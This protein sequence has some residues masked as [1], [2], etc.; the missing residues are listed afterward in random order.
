MIDRHQSDSIY[1]DEYFYSTDPPLNPIARGKPTPQAIDPREKT[2]TAREV[3]PDTSRRGR[4]PTRAAAARPYTSRQGRRPSRDADACAACC[5]AARGA[6]RRCT[7]SASESEGILGEAKAKAKAEAA[8]GL[9]SG[10]RRAGE[11]HD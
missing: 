4:R 2:G 8:A 11:E 5:P 10:S 9:V 7:P 6:S 3:I 1:G